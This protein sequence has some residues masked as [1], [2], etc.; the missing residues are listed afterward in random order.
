MSLPAL[1]AASALAL[2]VQGWTVLRVNQEATNVAPGGTVALCQAIPVTALTARLR[3]SV[4]GPSVRV[5][6]RAPGHRPRTRTVR[7]GRRARVTFTARG[8]RLRDEAF[9]EGTYRL[10]VLRGGRTLD[11]ATLRMR[12]DGNC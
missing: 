9:P 8:L 6:M 10:R 1:L 2:H 4:D 3:A 11:R 7:V 5:R 12:G